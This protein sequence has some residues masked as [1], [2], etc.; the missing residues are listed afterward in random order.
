MCRARWVS[1]VLVSEY[2]DARNMM[3]LP[4]E[5]NSRVGEQKADP[6]KMWAA[7]ADL[8]LMGVTVDH[9]LTWL[10]LGMRTLDLPVFPGC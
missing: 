10:M 6:T 2:I 3:R 9:H 7:E 1:W 8:Q 4:K 5:K